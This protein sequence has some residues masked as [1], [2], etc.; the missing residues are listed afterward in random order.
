MQISNT[1]TPTRLSNPEFIAQQDER[2]QRPEIAN[3][4]DAPSRSSANG[5]TGI[6]PD[7]LARASEAL[8]AARVQRLNDIES[9]PLK[10]QQALNSYQQTEEATQSSEFGELVGIDLYV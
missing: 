9:A 1:L 3:R 5:S 7:E 4:V 6:D 10:T 8:Q 2:R